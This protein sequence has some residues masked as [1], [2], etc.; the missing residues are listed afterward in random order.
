MKE[1]QR[2]HKTYRGTRS[3]EHT[4]APDISGAVRFSL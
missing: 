3:N 2:Q 4:V 1:K